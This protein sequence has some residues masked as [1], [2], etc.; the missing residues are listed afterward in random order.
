M[1][2][3][4]SASSLIYC[5]AAPR[6]ELKHFRAPTKLKPLLQASA[7]LTKACQSTD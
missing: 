1:A 6:A 5:G 3:S 4:V 2:C 7:K